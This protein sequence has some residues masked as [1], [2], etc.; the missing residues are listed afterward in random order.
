[1][2]RTRERTLDAALRRFDLELTLQPETQ[3][4]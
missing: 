4:G 1:V 2:Q 3:D